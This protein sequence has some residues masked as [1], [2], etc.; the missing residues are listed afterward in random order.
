M[1][2]DITHLFKFFGATPVL[3]D[4]S[5]NISQKDRIGLVGINGA[6]KSTLLHIICQLLLP[7]EGSVTKAAGIRI[8]YLKQNSDFSP[9][10]TVLTELR[11]VFSDV[12]AAEKKM[13]DISAQMA[14][15]EEAERQ[16]L[17]RAYEEA[18]SYFFSRD[19]YQIDVKIRTILTG[20]GFANDADLETNKLSGGEKTRLSIAKLL[21]EEPDLL[22]LDEPTNHLDLDTLMWLEEYLLSYKGAVLM[23]S[24]DRYF[25]DRTVNYIWELENRRL[26]TYRG[27]YTSFLRQKEERIQRQWKEYEQ[28]Q[29]TVAS[30]QD[31][32]AR[33]MA[34]ASTSNSAKSR[35]H[36]LERMEMI[37]KPDG[38]GRS[39][40]F[41]FIMDRPS[42]KEVLHV[43][44]VSVDVGGH[45][46]QRRLF[47]HVNL[48]V[49]RKERIAIIGK[50]GV[51]KTTFFKVLEGKKE[52]TE[53]TIR[54]GGAVKCVWYDQEQAQLHNDK[55]VLQELWDRYPAMTQHQVKTVL[56]SVLFIGEDLEK[57]VSALSGGERARLLMACV[58]L[59]GANVLLLDEPS[60]HLDFMTQEKLEQALGEYEGTLV[61]VSH[62]RY[63]IN[64]L[65]TKIVEIEPD[66]FHIY[67]GDFDRYA[68]QK[69]QAAKL[70]QAEPAANK[71]KSPVG[72]SYYRNK[73]QRA[74]ETKMRQ[75]IKL[76][77]T[78]IEDTQHTIQETEQEVMQPHIAQDY[79]LLEEKCKQIDELKNQ[80]ESYFEEW[81]EL[82]AKL[83]E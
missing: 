49:V 12:W 47:S 35:V 72:E 46:G 11:D 29:Q 19:G 6:G 45:N 60:N 64:K 14:H 58:M 50:N 80:Y 15:E 8:G 81:I 76:L 32:V 7:D 9:A 3:T 22:I 57:S 61:F 36:A 59:S 40:A 51:G 20:M 10:A 1:L 28:Q 56:A 77:E 21:L 69:R 18:Q 83:E 53:G 70:P 82:C 43:D 34:R 4:V 16:K 37:E 30:M 44:D 23:V 5:A 48:H 33:N 27:N 25:L 41:K 54:W 74:K 67:E 17:M 68:E 52:P 65:A 13:K 2:I 62:D 71:V 31:F 38:P 24:H 66:G 26:F 75:R 79:L 55:T 63:L 39:S 73:E 78:L 42:H